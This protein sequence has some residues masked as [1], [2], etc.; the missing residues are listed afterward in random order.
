MSGGVLLRPVTILFV[1]G[2]KC[3]EAVVNLSQF[4]ENRNQQNCDHEQ[5]ELDNHFL[6]CKGKK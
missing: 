3:F 5:Q 4:P 1:L 2:K 6:A